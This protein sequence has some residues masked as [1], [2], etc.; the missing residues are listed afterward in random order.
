MYRFERNMR[1]SSSYLNTYSNELGHSHSP[2][3][4]KGPSK[5]DTDEPQI[6]YIPVPSN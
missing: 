3:K 5:K 4:S 2:P 1:F 6:V